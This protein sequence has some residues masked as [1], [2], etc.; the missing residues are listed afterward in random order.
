V[1]SIV[2]FTR[3][4]P[5]HLA[6]ELGCRGINCYEALAI[7]E[8]FHLCERSEINLVVID[9]SVDDARAKAVQEQFPTLRLDAGA[10]AE[11]TMWELT[12]LLGKASAIQ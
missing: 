2:Y 8:V 11:D 9:A 1:I 6:D 10:T 5:S 3:V 12:N 7:S 4:L